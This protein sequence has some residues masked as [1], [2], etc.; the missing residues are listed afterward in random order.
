MPLKTSIIPLES[1]DTVVSI[2]D[3]L[4]WAKTPRILLLW[5]KSEELDLDALD[6]KVLDRHARMLG[7]QLG[8]VT[9]LLPVQRDAK[10]LGIAVFQSTAAAQKGSWK[11][12]AQR[13]RRTWRR[14]SPQLRKLRDATRLPEA[15]W[16]TLPAVRTFT[17]ALGVVAV[18]GLVVVLLPHAKLTI[19]PELLTEEYTVSVRAGQPAA[20]GSSS[21]IPLNTIRTEL[22]VEVEMNVQGRVLIP[23][24]T[25]RG[26]VRFTNLTETGVEIPAGTIVY[27]VVDHAVRYSTLQAARLVPGTNDSIEV[28]IQAV[29]AGSSGNVEGDSIRAVEGAVGFAVA[30]TNPAPTSGGTD[31]SEIGATDDERAQLREVA[32]I[33]VQSLAETRLRSMLSDGDLIIPDSLRIEE[34][35]E[36]TYVP[37]AGSAG[38]LLRLTLEADI[39]AAYLES[40]DVRTAVERAAPAMPDG[41]LTVGTPVV[42]LRS[43]QRNEDGTAQLDV[44]IARQIRR[45]VDRARVLTLV[46]ALPPG[47]ASERLQSVFPQRQPPRIDLTPSWWPWMPLTA[48][49]VSIEVQ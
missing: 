44:L 29:L 49:G 28:P 27:A 7:A 26:V 15:Q 46:R 2:R 14:P 20:A 4:S 33:R 32:L 30:V 25:A 16:R 17:F 9:R 18:L 8:I 10:A 5:P 40:D 38:R 43:T 11:S 48:L 42:S 23:E 22:D 34:V 36:E 21:G 47:N 19:Y 41:Y 12:N 1:H 24:G 39:S 35:L 37:P 31:R 3:R 13:R 45:E 6:L